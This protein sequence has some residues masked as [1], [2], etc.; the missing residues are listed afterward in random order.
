MSMSVASKEKIRD[1]FARIG[2]WIARVTA[3]RPFICCLVL[4][5][6][7]NLLVWLLHARS[8]VEG[9]KN[10]VTHPIFFLFNAL[11]LLVTY[12][13]TLFFKRRV[14]A[15]SLVSVAWLAIGVTN[16][17]LLGMRA[18]PLSGIDFYIVRTG[19]VLLPTYMSPLG[20]VLTAVGLLGAVALLVL[21]FIRSPRVKVHLLHALLTLV[22]CLLALVLATLGVIGIGNADPDNFESFKEANDVYGFPY[23]FLRSIF[24]RGIP[25][26][27]GY[28]EEHLRA[29]LDEL[30]GREEPTPTRTP[31]VIFVQLESFF[32][33][34]R[35]KDLQFSEDPI[36]N[37][38]ALYEQCSHGLLSVPS[39]G[40]GTANT[41]FEVL[42]G[43]DLDLFGTGEYPYQSILGDTV[44]ETVAY[45]LAPFGYTAHG[46]HNHTGTFYDR[47][48]VYANLGF[49]TFTSAEHMLNV[50]YNPLGYETDEVLADYIFKAL[51]STDGQDFV[52]A[53]S[54]QGHGG[55]PEIPVGDTTITLSG[56]ENEKTHCAF[57]YYVNQLHQTDA[58]IGALCDALA[59]RDE[60]TVLVLYGDHLPALP[61]TEDEL[62]SG[63]LYATEYVIWANFPLEVSAQDL[64][65]YELFPLVLGKLGIQSGLINTIHQLADADERHEL[66]ALAGYDMLYG[67]RFAF[68]GVLP[69]HPRDMRQGLDPFS[70]TKLTFPADGEC[71]IIGEGFTPFS[72]VF[73]NGDR[74]N[75]VYLSETSLYLEAH[76]LSP[77]DAVTVAQI[78]A[79][80]RKLGQT[81]A[82]IVSSVPEF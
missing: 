55:Y 72:R 81:E 41:E 80:F 1:R 23:C 74:V 32:D 48:L 9:V 50:S 38:S 29:R 79:D 5:L 7:V 54:V 71:L 73:V 69:Y 37:F 46:M 11:I 40:G 10:A 63:D 4:A 44:C 60:E 66:L 31:N 22:C 28:S 42:T 56:I 35:V 67:D 33:V 65:A 68:G 36:P 52:F 16:C 45:D 27:D 8:L 77:G 75:A 58:V 78:S 64:E 26:P 76:S 47:Y 82:F 51:D 15:L 20:M 19:I 34:H 2:R 53:V 17:V 49:D 25:E 57:S 3:T 13:P 14:F 30:I 6:S 18:D 43:L 62:M 24:D 21:L 70:I 61:L 12:A 59:A 39:M